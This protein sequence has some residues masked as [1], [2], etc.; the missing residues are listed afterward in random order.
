MIICIMFSEYACLIIT[1]VMHYMIVH[2]CMSITVD[3]VSTGL[4]ISLA[5]R[6]M[7]AWRPTI[8]FKDTITIMNLDVSHAFLPRTVIQRGPRGMF[9]PED[10]CCVGVAPLST[11]R[12]QR[13]NR[14]VCQG[15]SLDSMCTRV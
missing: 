2:S 3:S 6:L 11:I 1:I 15:T 7:F 13:A 4:C 14:Y 5:F 9:K 10:L 12:W 8:C